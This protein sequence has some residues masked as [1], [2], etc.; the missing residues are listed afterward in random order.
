[1]IKSILKDH[2]PSVKYPEQDP[3]IMR[4]LTEFSIGP[5]IHLYEVPPKCYKDKKEEIIKE[6]IDLKDIFH[7]TRIKPN[8]AMTLS[9]EAQRALHNIYVRVKDLVK[10]LETKGKYTPPQVFLRFHGFIMFEIREKPISLRN[11]RDTDYVSL[12][13]LYFDEYSPIFLKKDHFAQY[14]VGK[15]EIQYFGWVYLNNKKCTPVYLK[16]GQKAAFFHSVKES[17]V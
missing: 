13:D 15:D 6:G 17:Q 16:P 7:I 1:M 14:L 3:H 4:Q 2:P 5:D 9:L 8:T 11:Y 10:E 12:F